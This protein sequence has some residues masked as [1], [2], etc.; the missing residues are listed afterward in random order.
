MDEPRCCFL[1]GRNGFADPLDKHHIFGGGRRNK[2]DKY[3]LYVYLCHDRCHE[4]GK[5]SVQ[6]NEE[7]MQKLHEWGQRK[8]MEEQ[9]W[10]TE[11][12]IQ[13]FGKNYI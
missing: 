5:D 10:D 4:N 7:I 8:V 11:R 1:C 2:S 13:E 12:F 6:N 9:G 3:G